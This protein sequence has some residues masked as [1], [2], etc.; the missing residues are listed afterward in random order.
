[1]SLLAGAMWCFASLKEDGG[2]S[3]KKIARHFAPPRHCFEKEK[4]GSL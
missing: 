1:M 3:K 4:W 2:T